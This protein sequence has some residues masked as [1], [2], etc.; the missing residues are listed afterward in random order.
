MFRFVDFDHSG[1]P[2]TNADY[3][4]KVLLIDLQSA[5]EAHATLVREIIRGDY[6][7]VL[8]RLKRHLPRPRIRRQTFPV[9][10]TRLR[11]VV[12]H[13]DR[14]GWLEKSS[15]IARLKYRTLDFNSVVRDK[16]YTEEHYILAMSGA[17]RIVAA[18]QLNACL[19]V[20]R[21]LGATHEAVFNRTH[22]AYNGFHIQF[23]R[24]VT[25]IWH[26]SWPLSVIRYSGQNP[27]ELSRTLYKRILRLEDEEVPCDLM[28][29]WRPRAYDVA[30]IRRKVIDAKKP[31][32]SLV[33][34][35]FGGLEMAGFFPV[36][37]EDAKRKQEIRDFTRNPRLY[38]EA[39]RAFGA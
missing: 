22:P 12:N 31:L 37:V 38:I 18:A 2:T 27:G 8:Q 23:V 24:Q 13:I 7:R 33:E 9:P 19:R 20:C 34:R 29:R 36:G 4:T 1:Y 10:G 16:F 15:N 14:R 30:I 26:N 35:P 3:D 32:T 21:I 25:P 39:L 28:F 6:D 5:D 11:A 17:M